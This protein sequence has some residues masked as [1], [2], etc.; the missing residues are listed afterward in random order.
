MDEPEDQGTESGV[1]GQPG[2]GAKKYEIRRRDVTR[3][4]PWKVRA[5][6]VDGSKTEWPNKSLVHSGRQYQYRLYAFDEEGR[7]TLV[8]E[9]EIVRARG[10]WFQTRRWNLLLVVL[11]LSG[12]VFYFIRL[13]KSGKKLNIRKIAGLEAVDEPVGRPTDT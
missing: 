13:A 4:R 12:T 10:E 2:G 8:G 1:L 11:A 9:T 3:D 5:K 7:R 6:D